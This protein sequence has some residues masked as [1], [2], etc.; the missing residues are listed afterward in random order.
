MVTKVD[1]SPPHTHASS[2]GRSTCAEHDCLAE[3]LGKN[4]KP[5]GE[6]IAFGLEP[7]LRT[8]GVDP[9]Q[10]KKVGRMNWGSSK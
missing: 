2:G 4:N 10:I 7:G 1:F 5:T 8:D 9:R 6:T 3:R